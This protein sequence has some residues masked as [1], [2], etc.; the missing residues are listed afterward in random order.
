MQAI[1][2]S[3]QPVPKNSV[4]KDYGCQCFIAASLQRQNQSIGLFLSVP[5]RRNQAFF[6]IIGANRS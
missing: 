1:P 5:S 2:Q 3:R 4:Q 6:I